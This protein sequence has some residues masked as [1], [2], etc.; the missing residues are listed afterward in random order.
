MTEH[1]I[2]HMGSEEDRLVK[3]D[4]RWARAKECLDYHLVFGEF[5]GLILPIHLLFP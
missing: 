3:S 1:R 5:W 2:T 4:F